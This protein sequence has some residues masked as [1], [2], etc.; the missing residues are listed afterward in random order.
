MAGAGKTAC[1]LELA[2]RHEHGRFAGQVWYR[3]PEEGRE[4]AT[5]LGDLMLEIERQLN[6]PNLNLALY[7]D[8][9]ELFRR[10]VLPRLRGFLE[11]HALLLVLDNLEHLLA[12]SGDWRDPLWGEVLAA[13]L[14]HRGL[15]RVVLTSRRLPNDLAPDTAPSGAGS[16]PD[17]AARVLREPIHALS[18]AESVLLARELPN[19]RRLLA[20]AEGRGLLQRTL[21]VVQ[22]H[23]KLL[24]LADGLAADRAAL[25]AQVAVTEPRAADQEA[26]LGAFFAVTGKGGEGESAQP[27]PAFV[28]TLY[29]WTQGVSNRLDPVAR[30]LLQFLCRLEP[31]DRSL[32]SVQSNWKGLLTRLRDQTP[33]A[34]DALALPDQGLAAG[35]AALGTVGLLDA[36]RP[37]PDPGQL[38]QPQT[39]GTRFRIHPG[40]AE[41][42]LAQAP[43]EVLAEA[44]TELG[45]YHIAV[46]QHGLRTEMEGGGGLVVSAGRRGAPYLMRGQRWD[47]AGALLEHM[48]QRDQS[49]ETLGLA[50]PLLRRTSEAT[51][52]TDRGLEH[53]GVLAKTLSLAGRAA[54]AELELR[55]IIADAVSARKFRLAS[56]VAGDLLNLLTA[57]GRLPEALGLA[58]DMAGYTREAGLGPWTRLLDET[59]RLQVLAAMGRYE[60]V[61]EQVETLRGRMDA[62]PEP[63][64][65]DEA[66]APWDVRETL[67]DTG[68]EAALGTERW[69]QALGLSAEVLKSL[70]GRGATDLELART[71]FND[72]GPL[73]RLGRLDDCR[74][75]LQGCRAVFEREHDVANVGKVFSALADL[76]DKTGDRGGA[77]GFEQ[78]ALRFGY[79]AGDPEGCAASHHNLSNYLRRAG[80]DAAQVL[81]HRLAAAA[82]CVQTGS[83]GL[84]VTIRNLANLELPDRP[85]PF[86]TTADQVERV[87]GVRFRTLFAALPATYPDGDAAIAAVWGLV[88]QGVEGRTAGDGGSAAQT[89]GDPL[90]QF[91][92]LLQAIAAVAG[93]DQGPRAQVEQL[94]AQLEQKG[95]MLRG[96]VQRLWSGER[97]ADSLTAGLDPQDSAL[98]R[99]L[100]ELL[101]APE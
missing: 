52:G 20:D 3:G 84:Q 75:L 70:S 9:P 76:Q 60:E 65:A 94:L 88:R 36:E 81:A 79:Q 1:A 58:G 24:E 17:L 27:E 5:A 97:S 40:V 43:P 95:W 38:A 19:L 53:A 71:R 80:A 98:I 6:A 11:Q 26:V 34:A 18:L 54:E 55:R 51:A 96:P 12:D 92:P 39:Q 82:L 56:A 57:A 13:L 10:L 29:R 16:G 23:P 25:A 74:Q 62:L 33:A 44:D 89:Q 93:G 77:I 21:W 90:R 78:A 2:Y 59:R 22:G 68:R 61:L 4:I 64:Q 99:R 28:D 100:L 14:G 48:T 8:Q 67:L 86:A 49:P 46:V 101:P 66:I 47:K 7:L 37:V 91:D 73:L 41:S 87:E 30:L 69:D 63:G 32:G 85:P 50:I 42:V 72:Y 35:L 83:G 31:E 15:S 45:N